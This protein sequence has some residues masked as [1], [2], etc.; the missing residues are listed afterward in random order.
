MSADAPLEEGSAYSEQHKQ[1]IWKLAKGWISKCQQYHQHHCTSPKAEYYNPKRLIDVGGP[2]PRLAN[3]DELETRQVEYAALSYCWGSSMPEAAKTTTSNLGLQERS[4]TQMLPRTFHDAIEICRG[5]GIPYLWI[6]ALCIIQDSQ[7]D[8]EEQASEM[9]L[10]Y[11]HSALTIA[12]AISDH[13]DGGCLIRKPL[14]KFPFPI[15][16]EEDDKRAL[17]LEESQRW[18]KA[19]DISESTEWSKAFLDNPLLKRGWEPYPSNRRIRLTLRSWTLQER[20]LSPRVLYFT[21][22]NVLWECRLERWSEKHPFGEADSEFRLKRNRRCLDVALNIKTDSTEVFS[23]PN[24]H[25]AIT[26]DLF[27]WAW[28]KT[29]ED[30]TSRSFTHIKDRLPALSG[31]ASE[32]QHLR[33]EHEEQYLAGLWESEMPEGLLWRHEDDFHQSRNGEIE[34]IRIPGHELPS[35]SWVSVTGPVWWPRYLKVNS[36]PE[37]PEYPNP[38]PLNATFAGYEIRSEP[39]KIVPTVRSTYSAL[40][41]NLKV[42]SIKISGRVKRYKPLDELREQGVYRQALDVTFDRHI[43]SLKS[44]EEVYVVSLL[45]EVFQRYGESVCRGVGLVVVPSRCEGAFERIRYFHCWNIGW[46]DDG[47]DRVVTLV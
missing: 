21:P 44:R 23:P 34:R 35:W 30:Y 47:E 29:V 4:L 8:W 7:Q 45:I 9:G 18:E 6:D 10:V 16:P 12:A 32:M 5:L 36:H 13:C 27:I 31:L 41:G 20:E 24:T 1:N 14:E 19:R 38:S 3:R 26:I 2:V 33:D 22:S 43:D 17:N 39:P 11:T 28:R 15:T 42:A 25:S 46:W 40:H 37:S